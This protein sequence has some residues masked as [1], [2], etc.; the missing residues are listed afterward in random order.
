MSHAE[1]S[2]ISLRSHYSTLIYS[3]I[4]C[5]HWLFLRRFVPSE[6]CCLIN[7]DFWLKFSIHL[8]PVIL[9]FLVFILQP[10][11]VIRGKG[12][13]KVLCLNWGVQ[14]KNLGSSLLLRVNTSAPSVN[15][16]RYNQEVSSK[17]NFKK[18]ICG[19]RKFL[20]K[21]SSFVGP[22]SFTL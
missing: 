8:H 19:C 17:T 3:T 21:H 13:H 16:R 1:E 20:S 14:T 7:Y 18:S 22:F 9:A 15:Y 5:L 2:W 11:K 12:W 10:S 4:L 6:L